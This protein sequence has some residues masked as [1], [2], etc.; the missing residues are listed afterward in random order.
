MTCAPSEDSD[1]PGHRHSLIRVSVCMKKHWVV[2]YP[3]SAQRRL[4]R[5]DGCPG[6]SAS[7]LGAL[8]ILLV[9]S[10]CGS[11]ENSEDFVYPDQTPPSPA[12]TLFAVPFHRTLK[13]PFYMYLLFV[14]T[15]FLSYLPL[16]I[17]IGFLK[18]E[19]NYREL[20]PLAWKIW[21]LDSNFWHGRVNKLCHFHPHLP[22][23]SF[24]PLQSELRTLSYKHCWGIESI[25]CHI[26]CMLSTGNA[27]SY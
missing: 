14:V 19:L 24:S 15:V 5:L 10:C 11:N 13:T 16:K 26:H 17:C 1:Q 23:Y 18:T 25:V 3:L 2:S 9:L 20:C 12:F 22:S 4:I 21:R 6:W 27:C 8:A 7:S